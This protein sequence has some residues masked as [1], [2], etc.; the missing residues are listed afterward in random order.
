MG[1]TSGL[2]PV[3]SAHWDEP[4]SFTIAGYRRHGGYTAVAKAFATDPDSVIATVKDSGLC[5]L[6][7]SDAADE[8]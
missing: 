7:T 6:Y 8:E 1:I 2:T 5:L 4:D 3:L